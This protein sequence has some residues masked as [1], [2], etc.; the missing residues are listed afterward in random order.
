[1]TWSEA[2]FPY[3]RE[4]DLLKMLAW[5][6]AA[7]VERALRQ[8]LSRG[9][10]ARQEDLAV[11]RGRIDF[12]RQ[13][14]RGQGRPLP[15]SCRFDEYTEDIELNRVLKAAHRLLAAMPGQDREVARRLRFWMRAFSD[16]EDLDYSPSRVPELGFTRLNQHW[17]QAGRIAE[18]VLRRETLTDRTGT[19]N[20]VAFTVDMNKLFEKFIEEVVADEARAAGIGLLPQAPRR[21]TAKVPMKPDL[22]LQRMGRDV[23]VGDAKY[24]ALEIEE[25]PNAD[26]YQLLGYCSAMGLPRGLLIYATA[27]ALE[28]QRVLQAGIELR[29]IGVDM[30][31]PPKAMVESARVAARELVAEA[32]TEIG[33]RLE[34]A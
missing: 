14:V 8:G 22:V 1:V 6:F 15:L 3:E 20:A 24:K 11:L 5:L 13:V 26:L 21:L 33:R 10:I 4:P 23:A 27:Q 25:M 17:E 29:V 19:V 30:T 31:L 34:V 7:E 32:A 12:V 16:V 28:V 9:Y 18:L 2:R